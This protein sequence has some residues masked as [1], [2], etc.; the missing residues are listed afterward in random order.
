MFLPE[1]ET[2][3][4]DEMPLALRWLANAYLIH[5]TDKKNNREYLSFTT[6]PGETPNFHQPNEFT[7]IILQET[8]PNRHNSVAVRSYSVSPK[9]ANI[10]SQSFNSNMN[11]TTRLLAELGKENINLSNEV[12]L[13]NSIR[14]K[15]EPKTVAEI[16]QMI[17]ARNIE[18]LLTI[19]ENYKNHIQPGE[20]II[21]EARC[22]KRKG[23]SY[24]KRSLILTDKPRLLYVDYKNNVLK[25]LIFWTHLAPIKA[26]SKGNNHFDI[27]L[28]D[29][30][31]NY[32]WS[33]KNGSEKWIDSINLLS[34][35]MV[36]Y[37]KRMAKNPTGINPSLTPNKAGGGN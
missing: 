2:D 7:P 11:L 18:Y 26:V 23:W 22:W 4:M 37:M 3:F 24:K 30:S 14:I 12:E 5:G 8:D 27:C 20:K 13:S 28:F 36:A 10:S 34:E 29:K 15:S 6:L 16:S 33:D 31:R 17:R 1:P 9:N 21:Q 35:A 19:E 25:G 32:H